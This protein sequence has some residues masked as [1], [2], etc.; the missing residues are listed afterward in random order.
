MSAPHE[1]RAT[2]RV[3]VNLTG[4]ARIGTRFLK[5]PVADLSGGG[6]YL[7][8]KE[9][10]REGTP[11]RVA[12]A[13]PDVDGPRICTLV[14]NV[15]RL[16]CDEKGRPIGIGVSFSPDQMSEPDI[17]TLAAWLQRVA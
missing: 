5:D 6:L 3:P 11:V 4:H 9:P 14:G 1:K 2:K 17:Q 13:L 10:F 8:T 12:V 15:A 7:K 16:D